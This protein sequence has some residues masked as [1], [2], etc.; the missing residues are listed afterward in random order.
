MKK[1]LVVLLSVIMAAVMLTGC[2]G[3]DAS[4]DTLAI[5]STVPSTTEILF[6][7][8]CGDNVVGIDVYSTYPEAAADIEKVGDYSGFDIEKVISLDPDVVFVGTSLQADGIAALED[9][10]LNVVQS[11]ATAY[12]DIDDMITLI[13][14]EV[15]KEDEAAALIA[16]ID[17]VEASVAQ[18]AAQIADKPTVYYVM[19]IGE[20]GNWTSGEGSF[21]NDVIETAGGVCVTAGSESSWMEYPVEALVTADPDIL[22]VSNIVAEDD[23]LA[24]V[25]Y[26][27]LTAVQNGT[28][29]FVDPNIFERPGPR[30]TEALEIAQGY[31]IG[32]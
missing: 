7:I 1:V 16:Q 4:Q 23:L 5:V 28:Y 32:E 3:G 27:D 24:E 19:G 18:A 21:I 10:G 25:G 14:T 15:C 9:A 8:G 17:E 11:E 26:S 2:A 30:I 29:Y 31:I 12:D 6:E 22:I 13:G 20:Y